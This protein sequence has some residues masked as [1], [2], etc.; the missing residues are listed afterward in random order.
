[1]SELGR[2]LCLLALLCDDILCYGDEITGNF[3]GY[4]CLDL[5]FRMN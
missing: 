5:T 3:V 2:H 4:F 1:M